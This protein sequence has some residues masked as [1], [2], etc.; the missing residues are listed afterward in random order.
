MV[1]ENVEKEIEARS[2]TRVPS[3]FEQRP[4]EES[5]QAGGQ[6]EGFSQGPARLARLAQKVA[7]TPPVQGW[8]GPVLPVG[9]CLT[10]AER[11][12]S[13]Q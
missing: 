5:Q 7:G 6:H 11:A 3:S 2:E 10:R 9:R 1:L 12:A 4:A 8:M 13:T